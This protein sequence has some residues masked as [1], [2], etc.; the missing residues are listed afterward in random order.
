MRRLPGHLLRDVLETAAALAALDRDAAREGLPELA[1]LLGA[2]SAS[3]HQVSLADRTDQV[4]IYPGGAAHGEQVWPAYRE[5]LGQ[6][7]LTRHYASGRDTAPRRISD[8]TSVGE[9]HRTPIYSEYYRA[10]Q[11]EHQMALP[12][13]LPPAE[14]LIGFTV[15]R[16]GGRDFTDSDLDVLALMRPHLAR[17][18]REHQRAQQAQSAVH[19]TAQRPPEHDSFAPPLAE[20]L[21]TARERQILT[22]A[23]AGHTNVR[24]AREL[25]V[26]HR[27]V[28]KHLENAYRKLGVASRTAAIFSS[29]PAQPPARDRGGLPVTATT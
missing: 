4:V 19:L 8:V 1:R 28:E 22:L 10:V 13:L 24:I 21:L 27:T 12:V 11:V 6:D 23:Q 20:P 7:P 14:Q 2:D 16:A 5:H 9:F 3:Y 25:Q 26:S 29:R 17:L 18:H 15:C